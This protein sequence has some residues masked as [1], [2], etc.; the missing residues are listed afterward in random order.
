M[1]LPGVRQELAAGVLL[2]RHRRRSPS[3]HRPDRTGP[4]SVHRAEV[5][6]RHR[7]RRAGSGGSAAAARATSAVKPDART[8]R[9]PP[10]LGRVSSRATGPAGRVPRWCVYSLWIRSCR[11]PESD[12]GVR[13]P[14]PPALGVRRRARRVRRAGRARPRRGVRPGRW[15]GTRPGRRARASPR[16]RPSTAPTP[17]SSISRRTV[18]ARSAPGSRSSSPSATARASARIVSRRAAGI[19]N[20]SSG[21]ASTSSAPETRQPPPVIRRVSGPSAWRRALITVIRAAAVAA[22]EA[23]ED[24]AG[25]GDGDLLADDRPYGHLEAVDG[26]RH[27]YP[28]LL[29]DRDGER[30][31]RGERARRRPRVGVQVEQP[32]AA[33]HRGREVAHVGQPQRRRPRGPVAASARRSP[34]PCG[35]RSTRRYVSAVAPPRRRA[36]AARREELEQRRARAAAPGTPAAALIVPGGRPAGRRRTASRSRVGAG[37]YTSRIVSLNCR[38]LPKPAANAI[39]ARPRSVVSIRIRAVC[40]RCARASASGPAP[41]SAVSIRCRWRSV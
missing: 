32:A 19:R 37:A 24:G 13:A 23:G 4:P 16:S 31:V 21:N 34:V 41:S 22:G 12:Q 9:R 17:G 10:S 7:R 20:A 35:R 14:G 15:A 11:S 5:R 18:S 40:A 1:H 39:S 25:A 36:R 3:G 6:P 8:H 30:R 27:A 2:D 26:A 33:R 29:R 38:T 28:R